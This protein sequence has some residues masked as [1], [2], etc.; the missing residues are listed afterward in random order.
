[1]SDLGNALDDLADHLID[2][3]DMAFPNAVEFLVGAER[4]WGGSFFMVSDRCANLAIGC[5][6]L[7]EA[8]YTAASA[9][10]DDRRFELEPCHLLIYLMDGAQVNSWPIAQRPP[11]GGYKKPHWSPCVV[12][13]RLL[14]EGDG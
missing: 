12:R 13:R 2:V 3:R 5:V 4:A 11:K 6:N 1:M 9:I 8:G 10:H 7:S 14:E